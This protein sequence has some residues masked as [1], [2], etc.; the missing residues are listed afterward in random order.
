MAAAGCEMARFYGR[1]GTRLGL[2]HAHLR[3]RRADRLRE[4]HD[5]AHV[6][7]RRAR[8]LRRPGLARRRHVLQLRAA[9]HRRRDPAHLARRRCA[10]STPSDDLWLGDVLERVEPAGNFLKEPSTRR[11]A[12]SGEWY[13][14]DLDMHESFEAWEAAGRPDV[15]DHARAKVDEILA[16]PRAAAARRRRREGAR[17]TCSRRAGDAS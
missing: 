13:I 9:D 17:A 14:S 3:A 12:R 1:A 10:G 7:A 11:N 15:R 16:E 4:G 2:R 6:D 8:R 5:G